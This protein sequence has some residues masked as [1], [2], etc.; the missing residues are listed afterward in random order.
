MFPYSYLWPSYTEDASNYHV[1]LMALITNVKKREQLETWGKPLPVVIWNCPSPNISFLGLFEDRP[2]D[3]SSFFRRVVSMMLDRSLAIPIR[4]QLLCYLIHAFQSLDCAIVRKE[5]APLVS[6]GV[7][8]N[9]ST[10]SVREN[11][12][13]Q[14]AHLKKTW[15]ASHKRYDAADEPT[16]SRLRFERSWLYTL[17]LDFLNLLFEAQGKPGT[18]AMC[19]TI[20]QHDTN[21]AATDETLYCERFTEFI[22][23]LQ[24]QLPTRRYVNTLLHDLHLLPAMKL[25]PMYCDEDNALLRDQYALLSHY[26]YF[27]IDDQTGA[28]LSRND[29]YDRHCARLAKLQRIALKH[30]KDKLV[31]LA[32][33]NY[34]SID[35]RD[36]L[37]PLLEPLT[38][39]EILQLLGLLDL[40]TTYPESVQVPLDRRFFVEVIVSTFEKRETFQESAQSMA[41]APTE[42]ALFDSSFRLA[43]EYDGSHP[44]AL[45]KLNLQYLS[46]GD[47]LWRSLILY[48]RE[49]FY[50]IRKDVESAIRRLKPDSRR[51]GETHF[52]GFSKM[53]LPISKPA[54]LEVVPPLVG[55]DIPSRVR[56]EVTVD[57]RRLGPGVRREWDTLRPDDVVF[58][59][60]VE[61]PPAQAISNGAGFLP[62]NEQLGVMSVRTAVITQ[63]TDEKGR[64]V[65]DGSHG[66]DSKRRI[67]LN[68]DPRTYVNDTEAAAAGRP[69]VYGRINLLLRRGRRE[70]NF[71]PVLESIRSLVLSEVPLPSW[72]HEV[73]LGY[74]DP[75]GA[76]HKNLANRIK[77]VDYRDTFLDWHHLVESLP[78]KTVEPDDTVSGSFGPPH[79]LETVDKEQIEEAPA[80]Q[81][82]PSKKRRRDADPALKA[83]VETL[84]VST[85]KPPNRGPYPVDEP[86]LNKVRFTSAQ[87]EAIMSGAQP[88]LSVVVGPPGTGKTD[89]AVQVINNIYHSFPEQ[90][91]LLV[92]HSNQ[93][94]NQ[95]F[96]KIVALDI[97][98]RHLL[99]LGHGEEDLLTDGSFSK[100]GRVESFLENRD[101]YLQ[102]V[103]KLAIS[104]GAP[105]AHDNSAETAGYFNTVYIEPAWTKFLQIAA[106]VETSV[107]DIVQAFPFH[108]YFADAPQ[109]LFPPEADRVQILDIAHGCFRHI[110]KIFTELADA[111][112]FE[113][114]RRERDKANYLL[115]N[116]ARIVAMTTT[117]AAIRRGEIAAL[118][119]HY[120][121]IV[122]EEAAQITEIETFIPMAMQKPVDGELNLQRVF[123]CGDHFQNS[124]VIQSMAFRQYANLEQSL[125]SR[126]VRL[127]V[128][129]VMLD[130]QGRARPSI[131][132]LYRWRYPKLEDLAD[133]RSRD[134]FSKANAGFKYDFQFINVP[135]Y[136][137][138]GESEPTPHFIQNLGE[139]E[140]AVALYQ[141][142]RLLGYPA[143]KISILATY[144]GQRALI[145]D[146]LNHRCAKNPIFGMP[147]AVATVDKYQ[148]EQND[149]KFTP[150]AT[151]MAIN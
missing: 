91:T 137:G 128:P 27:A 56:S 97:D 84:K 114:L 64:H 36:E 99:R 103:R 135:P 43:D 122:M 108:A 66:L 38:D 37:V 73:F 19:G 131:A 70:N 134:E 16:K 55:E 147:K 90:K 65:R 72:L 51:P 138:K 82:K 58:L 143:D 109:P 149:C 26:T 150:P 40:R 21:D 120:D 74:G 33:S 118:G 100:Y 145:R 8:H 144:A 126:L 78:G 92:A 112:P 28:Q 80:A 32:L 88:G 117:H 104:L 95:L 50:G 87:A 71:K 20:Q 35:K 54:I 106:S 11:Q 14:N 79:V 41:L 129:T 119:F 63:I 68:L 22:S 59:L 13:S 77:K 133:V 146:V 47:F 48:R 125:F 123:L 89:V 5:C 93:A 45:P 25:S 4:T 9:L 136:K 15:R 60:A 148:G 102:E 115:T 69:D 139:A 52:A 75:A 107:D 111:L 7:W 31:V 76:H 1:L 130:Q 17:L 113:L 30:F 57:V 124:P 67:Q 86:R 127:G 121:N 23:D 2:T 42:K 96:A 3:F 24:S 12:F 18:S 142:M 39:D 29:A 105:G 132:N 46:V 34:G 141:Y 110:S 98:G 62:E 116:E 140:Y 6:I 53:A 85:Y 151:K 83:D 101:S 81:K 49:A 10:D 44:L 61:P 94:L